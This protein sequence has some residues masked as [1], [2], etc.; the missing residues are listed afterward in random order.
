MDR[1]RQSQLPADHA[2]VVQF[3]TQAAPAPHFAGRVEH[4]ASGQAAHFGS[5]EELLGFLEQV[6]VGMLPPPA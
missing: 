4:L 5:P 6:L 1:T 3:R 2:F